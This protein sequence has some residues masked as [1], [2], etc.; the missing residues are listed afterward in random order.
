MKARMIRIIALAL[1]LMLSARAMEARTLVVYY[2]Y[3]NHM[4]QIA[5]D[6]SSMIDA[7]VVRIEPVDKSGGYELNNYAKGTQLLNAIKAA[8]DSLSSYPAIDPIDIRWADYDRVVIG[9]PLWWSQMAAV[10]QTFLFMNRAQLAARQLYLMVASYSS[11]I[12]GVEADARRLIP[13]GNFVSPSLW[14]NNAHHSNRRSLISAWVDNLH[15]NEATGIGEVRVS[16]KDG[17]APVV[18]DLFGRRTAKF[19]K[20]LLIVNG[21]KVIYKE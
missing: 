8:P 10:T 5:D 14:I 6:L 17:T 19:K 11:G 4:K 12:S 1:A 7:N 15:L 21:K 2:S 9:T 20:G 16:Q 3:T 13:G 18:F